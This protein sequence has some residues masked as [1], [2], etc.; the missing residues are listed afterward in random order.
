MKLILEPGR[1][2]VGPAGSLITKVLYKK[3]RGEKIF[4]IADAGMNDLIRPSLYGAFHQIKKLKEPHNNSSGA[5]IKLIL[6]SSR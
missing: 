6:S 3:N 2:L 4:I 1:F 5:S